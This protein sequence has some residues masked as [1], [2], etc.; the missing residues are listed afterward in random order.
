MSAPLTT[1]QN[2]SFEN[3]KLPADEGIIPWSTQ[4]GVLAWKEVKGSSAQIDK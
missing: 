1:G 3:S 4:T 2:E